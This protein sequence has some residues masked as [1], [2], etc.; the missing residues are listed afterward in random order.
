MP[1]QTN[2]PPVLVAFSTNESEVIVGVITTIG[3]AT[4]TGAVT[5][6]AVTAGVTTT[7]GTTTTGG[8]T[9]TAFRIT[10]TGS[11]VIVVVIE[12][13]LVA[14]PSTTKVEPLIA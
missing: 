1:V 13:L 9:T 4:T 3:A 7:A 14:V 8:V 12:P 5:T 2:F 6:G 11:L 10:I